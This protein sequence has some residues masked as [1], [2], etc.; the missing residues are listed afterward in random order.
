MLRDTVDIRELLAEGLNIS[1]RDGVGE[2]I[3]D[4]GHVKVDQDIVEV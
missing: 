3:V 4:C 2:R 1:G